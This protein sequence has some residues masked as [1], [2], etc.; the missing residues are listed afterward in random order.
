MVNDTI[1]R[2]KNDKLI[3]EYLAKGLQVQQPKTPKYYTRR[4]IQKTGSPGC[5]VVCSVSCHTN[6]ISKCVDFQL[7]P[8]VKNI[9]SYLRD[10]KDLLQKLNKVKKYR[11][12][13]CEVTI[14]KHTNNL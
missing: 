4:K 2:F 5:A 14:H 13:C 10:N 3:T 7:Q 9:P 11:N 1:T 8:N 12:S 6:T